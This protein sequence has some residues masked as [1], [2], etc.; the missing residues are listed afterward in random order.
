[1]DGIVGEVIVVDNA[2]VDDTL[3]VIEK[4][5]SALTL[6]KNDLNHGF[7]HACHQGVSQAFGDKLI[8]LNP[9]TVIA[10]NYLSTVLTAFNRDPKVGSI[11]PL[12]I[13]GKGSRLPETARHQP[14]AWESIKHI[15]GWSSTGYYQ[16]LP[17]TGS[18]NTE[19]VSGACLALSKKLWHK[20]GGFDK[21]YFM[22]AEDVDLSIQIARAGYSNKVLIDHSIIHLKGEST[23]KTD[24]NYNKA[25]FK[26]M[27]LFAKKYKG[28]LYS[29]AE[30]VLIEIVTTLLSILTWLVNGIKACLIPIV[31]WLVF[32]GLLFTV[33]YVW[34]LLRYNDI[35]YYN[36]S[37]SAVNYTSFSFL[38]VVGLYLQGVY[39][40]ERWRSKRLFI[41]MLIGWVLSVV[42]YGFM[43]SDNYN[44]DFLKRSLGKNTSFSFA[45]AKDY[46]LLPN[47][48]LILH[49]NSL[50]SDL[51]SIVGGLTPVSSIRYWDEPK[52][53]LVHGD[54]PK[55]QSIRHDKFS[56]YNIQQ[57]GAK[58]QKRLFDLI[59][60]L[61]LLPLIV[62]SN[63]TSM[64]RFC[65]NWKKL[66]IGSYTVIGYDNDLAY[67]V[68]PRSKLA[69]WNLSDTEN[70][71]EIT[72][73]IRTYS[74][75]YSIFDDVYV[76]MINFWSVIRA[77]GK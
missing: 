4:G 60:G 17:Q 56:H 8:F 44:L 9:D 59:V 49:V 39:T 47:Q 36:L 50:N 52:Q 25:F 57:A 20:T 7:A 3:S 35:S 63:V 32:I 12:L 73:R 51:P 21:R 23:S 38:W 65:R 41:G 13:D 26:S 16:N 27:H 37:T 6:I 48:D 5:Y 62:I 11:T 28:D 61:L 69:I 64:N 54:D 29:S 40:E 53:L 58:I 24:W 2:S 55:R 19:I 66:I 22:Y 31:H 10:E 43:N 71:E 45:R 46:D 72:S 76:L 14:Q 74:L 67:D 33:Q 75:H 15:M 68:A 42:L 1:M 77:F 34:S 18:I 70:Q 30:V